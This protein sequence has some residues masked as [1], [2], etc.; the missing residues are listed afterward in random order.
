MES[1][2]TDWELLSA[3][4]VARILHD[5]AGPTSGLTSAIDLLTSGEAP[6]E[7][8]AALARESLA[9]IAER[10]AFCRAAFGGGRLDGDG[11]ARLVQAPFAGGRARLESFSAPHTTPDTAARAVLVIA[12]ILAE[13]LAS[14]G[15]AAILVE[16]GTE[17]WRVSARAEG[18]KVRIW[19]E[20]TAGLNGAPPPEGLAG[21]WAPARYLYAL[22]AR[23]DGRLEADFSEGVASLTMVF[24]ADS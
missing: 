6:R 15:T 14:G 11:L 20:T 10:I 24:P 1:A 9:R 21:R 5:V 7:E 17:G 19:P 2:E 12:Q 4:L 18:P 22:A 16:T 23:R 13:A 3:R 8:S